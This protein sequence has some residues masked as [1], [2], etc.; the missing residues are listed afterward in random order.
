MKPVMLASPEELTFADQLDRDA[1]DLW[2]DD[3]IDDSTA[4]L[5][6]ASVISEH[7]R[8]EA[9]CYADHQQLD[10]EGVFSVMRHFGEALDIARHEIANG[11]V[12]RG[13]QERFLNVLMARARGLQQDVST[14]KM[15][16]ALH[17]LFRC[18]AQACAHRQKSSTGRSLAREARH[19][20]QGHV[21]TRQTQS[22]PFAYLLERMTRVLARQTT[23]RA[24]HAW[25]GRA[26][27]KRGRRIGRRRVATLAARA[28]QRMHFAVYRMAEAWRLL[29]TFRAWSE[30]CKGEFCE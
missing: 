4:S 12:L 15:E 20:F 23:M 13:R 25:Y 9:H 24:L 11:S 2:W 8:F 7:G 26:L 28:L 30:S 22:S 29:R 18:W 21:R 14:L 16:L 6:C 27:E 17:R 1:L 10:Y 5:R 19:R 3:V